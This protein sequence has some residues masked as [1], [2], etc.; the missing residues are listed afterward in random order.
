[1]SLMLL[2]MTIIDRDSHAFYLLLVLK[3]DKPVSSL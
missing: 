3:S 2:N 1:M